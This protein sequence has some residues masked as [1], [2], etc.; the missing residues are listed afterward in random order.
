MTLVV[1]GVTLLAAVG[2]AAQTSQS[3]E[4]PGET[5][6][7]PAAQPTPAPQTN[8]PQSQPAPSAGTPQTG[9]EQPQPAPAT[10]E[11]KGQLPPVQVVQPKPKPV[12]PAAFEPKPVVRRKV[13]PPR[14]TPAAVPTPPTPPPAVDVESS[15]SVESGTTLVP[16]S[17][18]SGAEIPIGKVPSAVGIV[19]SSDFARTSDLQS[20]PDLLQERVP[21]IITDDLQGNSFQFDVAYR[22]FEASPVDG[23]PQGIAVYQNGVRINKSFGDI[24]NWDFLPSIAINSMMVL[25]NNPVYGLNALGGAIT[26]NMKDGFL[27]HGTE[28]SAYGGSYGRVGGSEQTGV[29]SGNWAAYFGGERIEDDGWRQFSPSDI[30]RMYAD[31]GFKNSDVE[32]HANFTAADNFYGVGAASPVQLLDKGWNL[33]FTTPQTTVNKMTMEFLTYA[34][35]ATDILSFSGVSYLRQFSQFHQDGN[36]TDAQPCVGTTAPMTP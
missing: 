34:V 21:G 25:P 27:Y 4:T 19:T 10:G 28:I 16:M 22:G 1:P 13:T 36:P 2:A 17:P 5:A 6:S 12:K 29:Q 24:V 33:A 23:V 35:K 18:V 9:A 14:A 26:I 20:V 7:P 30:R 11:Q 3:T 32:I 31:L 15:G 8:G